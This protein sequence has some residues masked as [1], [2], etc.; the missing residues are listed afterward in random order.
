[1]AARANTGAAKDSEKHR[2]NSAETSLRGKRMRL[3]ADNLK[4]T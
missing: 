3:V 4:R 1:L 2:S